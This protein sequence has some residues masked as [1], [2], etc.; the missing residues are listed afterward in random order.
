L[1]QGIGATFYAVFSAAY[2]LSLPGLPTNHILHDLPNFR[3][4]L[5]IFGAIFLILI[6]ASLVYSII[7]KKED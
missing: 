7:A 2:I 5:S 4:P 1:A 3:I 6:I